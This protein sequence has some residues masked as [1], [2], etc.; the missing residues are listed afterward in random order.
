MTRP[1][2]SRALT[3][4]ILLLAILVLGLA[5]IAR[6][7]RATRLRAALGQFQRNAHQQILSR[8]DRPL[9]WVGGATTGTLNWEG[10]ESLGSII[11]DLSGLA[12]RLTGLRWALV[13]RVDPA[14][15]AEAGQTPDALVQLPEAPAAEISFDQLFE[16]AL[17][18]CQLDWFADDGTLTITSREAVSRENTRITKFLEQP[19]V[20]SWRKGDSLDDVIARLRASTEGLT[21]PTGLPI[22]VRFHESELFDDCVILRDPAPGELSVG[23]QLR[24]I[25]EPVGLRYEV[26]NGAVMIVPEPAADTSL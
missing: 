15:L 12:G 3:T 20:L 2:F 25:L 13:V 22:F 21:F 18:P 5:V 4:G 7:R 26:K 17:G 1:G 10:R 16:R 6:E 8:M 14:G 9:S 19:V 11:R 24:R 23:E